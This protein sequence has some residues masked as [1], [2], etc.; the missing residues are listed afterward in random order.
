[1]EIE[2]AINFLSFLDHSQYGNSQITSG[3]MSL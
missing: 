1:M 3:F 2:K